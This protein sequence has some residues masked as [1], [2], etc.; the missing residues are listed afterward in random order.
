[1]RLVQVQ[2]PIRVTHTARPFVPQT[3]TWRARQHQV[4]KIDGVK[5]ER[6]EHAH[7]SVIRSVFRIRTNSGMRCSISYDDLRKRWLMETVNP[8]GESA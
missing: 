1:M 5:N 2:E 7:G 4:W 8:K 3:F 6:I